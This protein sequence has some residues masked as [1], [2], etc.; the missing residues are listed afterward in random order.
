MVNLAETEPVMP[1]DLALVIPVWNDAEGL[2]RILA[3]AR[4][5]GVFAQIVVIDD[6]SDEPVAH[7]PDITLL[8]ED[9]SRGPGPAR[10]RGR[11]TVQTRYLMYL[12]A[13]DLLTD[14]LPA[15]L[16]DLA[17]AGPFDLCLFKH[18]DSRCLAEPRW[19][20]PD[21]DEA[22]WIAAGHA[23]GALQEA[24]EG[25]LPHLAQTANYPWNKIY[26]TNF[27]RRNGIGCA[28]LIVHQDIPLHWN[29]LIQAQRVLVS[30]RICVAH[31][32]AMG[33]GR[34]TNRR[35]AERLG[36]FD[37]LDLVIAQAGA[38]G[39]AWQAALTAF[40]LRLSIWVAENIAPEHLPALH[41]REREWLRDRL[42]P[43]AGDIAQ[44]DPDT[45][46]AL[47]ARVKRL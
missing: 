39:P 16:A 38:A 22:H 19:G 2:A 4:D 27:L 12:D 29:A 32:V 13:D 17:E 1:L 18:A 24:R 23:V 34:L 10:N 7:A 41:Q 37:A 44:I 14:E 20:Q 25:A 40:V 28:D 3:Q 30:D 9:R 35:G 11:D 45:A 5:M 36:V 33:G 15:L 6:G 42:L 31:H 8:R 21:W 26:N 46:T 47:R 43:W